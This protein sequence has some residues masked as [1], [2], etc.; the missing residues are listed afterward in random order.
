MKLMTLTLGEDEPVRKPVVAKGE[1]V[2]TQEPV[3]DKEGKYVRQG[4]VEIHSFE[5]GFVQIPT[6]IS[7]PS[8]LVGKILGN[9]GREA[10]GL[11]VS[12]NF[13][14]ST[15]EY[16]KAV[17]KMKFQQTNGCSY[18]GPDGKPSYWQTEEDAVR[19]WMIENP[20]FIAELTQQGWMFFEPFKKLDDYR[21]KQLDKIGI[22]NHDRREAVV[23][24]ELLIRVMDQ[25]DAGFEAQVAD[26][27]ELQAALGEN[28]NNMLFNYEVRGGEESVI[29]I[30]KVP[31]I[32][33][34]L[35]L[36]EFSYFFPERKMDQPIPLRRTIYLEMPFLG[37]KSTEHF[38]W[39][40]A[41]TD[42]TVKLA[43]E[44]APQIGLQHLRVSRD[45]SNPDSAIVLS[46]TDRPLFEKSVAP[47]NTKGFISQAIALRQFI[48]RAIGL[49]EKEHDGLEKETYTRRL[50]YLGM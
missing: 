9:R 37:S 1:I 33:V 13:G 38:W 30:A 44:Y 43:E 47:V 17:K 25:P 34:P 26:L 29:F 39:T 8:S 6:V 5:N 50:G 28:A 10:R 40:R 11:L 22:R 46:V 32:G 12:P 42:R 35:V 15:R 36:S 41:H 49:E 31:E 24:L 23:P 3:I 18:R 27:K 7:K 14:E 45:C 20:N 16:Y 48:S 19:F 4:R 2:S 21:A